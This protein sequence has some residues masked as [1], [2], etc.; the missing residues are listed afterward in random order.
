MAIYFDSFYSLLIKNNDNLHQFISRLIDFLCC[1]VRRNGRKWRKS[2]SYVRLSWSDAAMD[3]T[4][5]NREPLFEP[6]RDAVLFC[7][8]RPRAGAKSPAQWIFMILHYC[9][10]LRAG[11]RVCGWCVHVWVGDGFPLSERL[12][13]QK[14]VNRYGWWWL[15][16]IAVTLLRCLFFGALLAGARD[17]ERRLSWGRCEWGWMQN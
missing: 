13:G 6:N 3:G 12:F 2:V 8:N 1:A 15:P 17:R 9:I 10:H 5:W 16:V 7:G 11:D 4:E 14:G